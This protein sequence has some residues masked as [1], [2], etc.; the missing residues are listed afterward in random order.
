MEEGGSRGGVVKKKQRGGIHWKSTNITGTNQSADGEP[1]QKKMNQ[2]WHW[3]FQ[4]EEMEEERGMKKSFS[5]FQFS[6]IE[7]RPGPQ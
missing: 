1:T 5:S 7:N 6:L 2:N 3:F 4:E